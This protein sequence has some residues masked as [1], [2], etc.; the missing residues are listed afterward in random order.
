MFIKKLCY[1]LRSIKLV[2]RYIHI[3][4]KFYG[5]EGVLFYALGTW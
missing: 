5:A 1:S 4:D 2:A 3:S